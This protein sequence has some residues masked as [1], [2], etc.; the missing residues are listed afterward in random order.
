MSLFSS[1]ARRTTVDMGRID[2]NVEHG[3]RNGWGDR[4]PSVSLLVHVVVVD[5]DK[6]T[7]RLSSFDSDVES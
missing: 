3:M 1:S 4:D 6:E 5:I 7:G 2:F